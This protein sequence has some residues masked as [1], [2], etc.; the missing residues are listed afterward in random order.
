MKLQLA[1]LGRFIL[2]GSAVGIL[3]P[4]I[5]SLC[6]FSSTLQSFIAPAAPTAGYWSGAVTPQ[7]TAIPSP[8][9]VAGGSALRFGGGLAYVLWSVVGAFA[10][11]AVALGRSKEWNRP[12]NAWFGA[13]IGSLLFIGIAVCG[14]L[15]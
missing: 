14:F 12:R 4:F 8:V 10:G 9:Q 3:L 2:V 6:L 13:A 11:E 1:P 7:P 5:I 15:R